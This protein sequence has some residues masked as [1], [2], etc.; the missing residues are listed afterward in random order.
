MPQKMTLSGKQEDSPMLVALPIAS[1]RSPS[2]LIA[3]DDDSILD[4]LVQGF[5]M[6]GCQVLTAE[7]G[8]DAWRLFNGRQVDIVLTDMQMPGLDGAQLS[9]RIRNHSPSIKIGIMTGGNDDTA[10]DLLEDGTV[11]CY[12]RKPFDLIR[13]CESMVGEVLTA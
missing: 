4:L 3:D 10:I 8:C 13:V 9:Q 12:F 6:F 2:V 1:R 5:E 7:N 11:D